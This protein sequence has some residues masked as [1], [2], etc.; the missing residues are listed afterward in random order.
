[1][2]GSKAGWAFRHKIYGENRIKSFFDIIPNSKTSNNNWLPR[3]IFFLFQF[4]ENGNDIDVTRN[5]KQQKQII[6][7]CLNFNFHVKFMQQSKWSRNQIII[8]R[9]WS[10]DISSESYFLGI[11]SWAMGMLCIQTE[12]VL[13]L[14]ASERERERAKG[15]HD[16]INIK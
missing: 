13:L 16:N 15:R 12:W 6:L 5:P 14:H 10:V 9:M 1:M 2:Y 3:K 4:K 8:I 11:Y 7:W